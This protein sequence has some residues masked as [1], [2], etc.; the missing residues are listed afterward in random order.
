MKLFKIQVF[1]RE[2]TERNVCIAAAEKVPSSADDK[3]FDSIIQKL[4]KKQNARAVVLFTRAEDARRI[5]EAS[6]RSNLSQ[7]F[8]WIA[9]DGWGRQNK[10]VEGLEDEAEGAIT[11]ELQSK[12]IPGFDDYIAGLRPE[13][14]RRN[15]WFNEYWEEVFS[16]TLRENF[17]LIT[18]KTINVCS[19]KLKLTQSNGYEQES[20]VQFVVDAIYAFAISLHNLQRDIC[21]KSDALC[22]AMIDYDKGIFYKKYL[23]NVS[24]TGKK[25]S[26]FSFFFII[27]Q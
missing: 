23:L 21:G 8:Q 11:V 14:N 2:A 13:T 26:G 3:V 27:I 24:F 18:N 16:C 22:Q 25:L 7:P 9:S 17:P 6:R 4:S 1:T 12:N 15:P 20:K 5:L 10:L 19:P